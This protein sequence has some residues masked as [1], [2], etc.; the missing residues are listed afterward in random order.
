MPTLTI[1]DPQLEKRNVIARAIKHFNGDALDIFEPSEDAF[2]Y[3]EKSGVAC[4]IGVKS[5]RHNERFDHLSKTY[6]KNLDRHVCNSKDGRVW[7]RFGFDLNLRVPLEIEDVAA[8]L[9][10]LSPR[11]EL[12]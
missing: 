4:W 9:E 3:R 12:P 6:F 7:V 8:R 11:E 2:L 5:I 1:V 10:P